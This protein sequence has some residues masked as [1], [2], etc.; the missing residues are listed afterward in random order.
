MET[1]PRTGVNNAK[2][3]PY[4]VG[5]MRFYKSYFDAHI[6]GDP[7]TAIRM[8]ELEEDDI[9]QYTNRLALHKKKDGMLIG[10]TRTS[11]GVI[12]FLRMAFKSYHQKFPRWFNP[13]IGLEAPKPLYNER[14]A[15]LED[16]VLSLFIP[17][18]LKTSIEQAVCSCMFLSGLRR[19]EIGA[20]RPEDL[21]WHTPKIIVRRA[22]Q[23]YDRKNKV[24]GPP[25]GKRSR[26]APFDP[27]LQEAIK[28]L[29]QEHGKKEWVF[30]TDGTFLNS[31]W[32][33][34][35]LP[36][37]LDDAEIELNG[38]E[39]VPHSARHSLATI[40]E[41]RG[42]AERHIQE[43]LGHSDPKT[44]RGYLHSTSKTIRIIGERITEA[45]EKHGEIEKQ[46]ATILKFKVS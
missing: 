32:I 14:D 41:V 38:R 25:K 36:K 11:A 24:L 26:D 46:K 45:R 6:K 44:T 40:L 29:W 8:N 13:F 34:H 33:R 9:T 37:W 28:T 5:T 30:S 31:Q 12:I 1:S 42:V 19:A 2:N 35:R 20:L 4:S 7:I 21:D 10:G 17:G 39:I 23:N 22:W 3:R 43:L 16:E 18:V 27:L 15:L